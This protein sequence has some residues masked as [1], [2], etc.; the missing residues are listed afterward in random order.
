[1]PTL[2]ARQTIELLQRKTTKFTGP[3]LWTPNSPDLVMVM[4]VMAMVVTTTVMTE[5][6]MMETTM[7]VMTMMTVVI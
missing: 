2:H 5:M 6:T 3:D 7:V 4:V 1:V